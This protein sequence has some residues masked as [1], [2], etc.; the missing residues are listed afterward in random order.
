MIEL[1][2]TDLLWTFRC[3]RW[4]VNAGDVLQQLPDHRRDYLD[5][6]G[7][8]SGGRGVVRRVETGEARHA[9]LPSYP[10]QR[11][12]HLGQRSEVR[13]RQVFKADR[14]TDRWEVVE[15]SA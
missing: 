10:P 4:P 13:I 11:V 9:L 14:A 7:P 2:P 6:E 3:V 15:S 12:L 8:I 5:Y 1:T